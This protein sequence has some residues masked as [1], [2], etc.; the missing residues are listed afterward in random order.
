[1]SLSYDA[2]GHKLSVLFNRVPFYIII[3]SLRSDRA[4]VLVCA[5]ATGNFGIPGLSSDNVLPV[6]RNSVLYCLYIQ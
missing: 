2:S 3:I 1:M 4:V 5:L 6:C